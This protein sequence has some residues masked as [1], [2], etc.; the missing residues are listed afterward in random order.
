MKT[1][2]EELETIV[3]EIG[4]KFAYTSKGNLQIVIADGKPIII[5]FI[6]KYNYARCIFIFIKM[7][8]QSCTCF[9]TKASLAAQQH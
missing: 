5:A 3:Q 8:F 4:T 2:I 9:V 6:L 1:Q 7:C